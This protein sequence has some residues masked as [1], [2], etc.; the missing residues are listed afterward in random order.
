MNS[1]FLAA[2]GLAHSCATTTIRVNDL[3]IGWQNKPIAKLMLIKGVRG[4]SWLYWSDGTKQ[5]MAYTIKHYVSQ[6]PIADFIRVHQNCLVNRVFVQR[7]QLTHRGPIV[8]LYT[9][10]EIAVSR[11]RWSL[12]KKEFQDVVRQDDE[13]SELA[14]HADLSRQKKLFRISYE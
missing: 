10:I 2:E 14:N 4:Y 5:L 7:T 13:A 12:V 11:R 9:G 6:L 1:P 3:R 8:R